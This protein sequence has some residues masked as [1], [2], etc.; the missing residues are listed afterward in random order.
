MLPIANTLEDYRSINKQDLSFVEATRIILQKQ[1][2]HVE[3]SQFATSGSLPVLIVNNAYVFKFFPPIFASEAPT[4][5]KALEFLTAN[6][7]A[8]P[9][10]LALEDINGWKCVQMTKLKGHN[11]KDLWP[12]L[13]EQQRQ[14]ACQQVGNS[15]RKIHDL[16]L[17][18]TGFFK[19]DWNEFLTEQKKNCVE[20]HTK[21]G[22]RE[23]L[24]KQIP[25]FLNS[26]ELKWSRISFLHTEV[27]KDHVLFDEHLN[28]QGFID[29]EPSRL[30]AAEYDFAA[31]AVFLSSGDRKAL[32]SFYEGYGSIAQANTQ[33]F[34]RQALAYTLL[35]QYS[36]LKWYLE[37]MPNADTLDQL[38]EL[39]WAVN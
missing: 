26:V 12:T 27:M 38:A 11:L 35:H 24:L 28:F 37:F 4:E 9:Q 39:W 18:E 36:N 29:F 15:L 22:L 5:S 13:N 21:L 33:E 1:N 31:V 23:D 6:A 16:S 8:A 3:I 30:G 34:K 32:R 20:R 7:C 19:N 10:L 17:P 2:L 14:S 25:D